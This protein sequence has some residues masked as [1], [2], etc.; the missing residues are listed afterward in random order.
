[1]KHHMT[2]P[3]LDNLE[4]GKRLTCFTIENAAENGRKGGIASGVARRRIRAMVD[5]ALSAGNTKV[6]DKEKLK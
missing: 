2:Q 1:M 4:I 5:M 6:T 3:Q